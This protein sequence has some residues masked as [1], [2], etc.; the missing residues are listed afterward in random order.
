VF[1]CLYAMLI[2]R[3]VF[4]YALVAIAVALAWDSSW[5]PAIVTFAVAGL[6]LY[7][8][9]RTYLAERRAR[10]TCVACYG[11]GRFRLTVS[12]MVY[13]VKTGDTSDLN[14]CSICNGS[15]TRLPMGSGIARW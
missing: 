7:R 5:A 2:A 10:G 8:R 1:Q 13:A 9:H 3:I 14:C 4:P 6:V 11:T 15:G 12:T